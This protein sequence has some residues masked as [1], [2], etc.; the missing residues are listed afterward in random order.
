MRRAIIGLGIGLFAVGAEPATAQHPGH[1]PGRFGNGTPKP[2]AYGNAYWSPVQSFYAGGAPVAT[3]RP[4]AYPTAGTLAFGYPG[5][6]YPGYA[7][8]AP[9]SRP[10]L[11]GGR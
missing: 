5:L 1:A 3:V 10:W 6:G 9:S 8:K 2:D 11:W 7:P 4:A